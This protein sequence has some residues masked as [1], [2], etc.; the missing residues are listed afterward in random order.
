MDEWPDEDRMQAIAAE[1]NLSETAFLV[2]RG[3]HY[4]IRWFAPEAEVDLCG[5]ATL[6]SAFVVSRFLEPGAERMEFRSMSGTLF[7][8]REGETF[9]LDFPSRPPEPADAPP[10]LERALGA[11]PAGVFLSRDLV[12]LL[13]SERQVRDLAPDFALLKALRQSLG[14]IVT[15]CGEKTDFVSRCFFPKFGVDEDPVTG[16]AHCSLIPFWAERLKKKRMTAAQLSK[17]GGLLSCELCGKRVKIGGKAVL[18]LAGEIS[19]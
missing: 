4:D 10:E 14:V 13:E 11:A 19:V 3:G 16:S 17:R 5:H 2:R 1:N 6:G 18:Y 15:A 12:V 9:T 8:K 7:A